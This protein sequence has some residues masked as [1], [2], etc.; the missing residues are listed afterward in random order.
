VA[1]AKSISQQDMPLESSHEHSESAW[2]RT[3][4]ITRT[5]ERGFE[6]SGNRAGAELSKKK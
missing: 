4:A 1:K 6:K 2:A 3:A 5:V